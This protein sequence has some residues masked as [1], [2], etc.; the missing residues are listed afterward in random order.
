L[1]PKGSDYLTYGGDSTGVGLTIVF[2]IGGD[3]WEIDELDQ[4]AAV[5]AG[6]ESSGI[7]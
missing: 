5:A 3:T 4:N 7:R 2:A 6:C 1:A